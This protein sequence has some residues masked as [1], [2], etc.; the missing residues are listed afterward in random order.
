MNF[1]RRQTLALIAALPMAVAAQGTGSY[2]TKPIRIIIPVPAG[3]QTD[4]LA[5]LL[6]QKIGDA[7]GQPVI[8]E[9]KAGAST[10]IATEAVAK[11]PGDGYTL[12]MTLTQFVQNPLLMPKVPY[13]VFKDFVPV[14][15][16]AE[17]TAI[18]C[19]G[20]DLPVKNLAEFVALAKKPGS[21]LTYGSN[22]HA[23]TSHMYAD[24]LSRQAGMTLTHVPYKGEAQMIPDIVSGRLNAGFLSGMAA[25]QQAKEGKVRILATT[26]RKRLTSLPNAPTFD[27]QGF[28]GLD[29]DGWVGIFAPSAT[30]TA[31]VDRLSAEFA[32]AIAQP[33]VRERIISFGLEPVGGTSAEFTT[34]VRRSHEEWSRIV[35]TLDMKLL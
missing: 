4:I 1:T 6:G 32:K 29:A 25:N 28:K 19:V 24:M 34:V 31:I 9:S 2:P 13:D 3:G 22:G 35:K 14:T 11:A 30:P 21:L 20:S 16:V 7:L 18:F 23:S 27:E 33:D 8:V 10:M 26:G 17:S 5:R 12:L 15:R